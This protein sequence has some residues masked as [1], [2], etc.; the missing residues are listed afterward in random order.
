MWE[1]SIAAAAAQANKQ[2][3]V[4]SSRHL[5]FKMLKCKNAL[6][7][8]PDLT[9]RKCGNSECFSQLVP[10]DDADWD[11]PLVYQQVNLGQDVSRQ[12][13]HSLQTKKSWISIYSRK[14]FWN[15]GV[16]FSL[17]RELANNRTLSFKKI[18]K[19]TPAYSNTVWSGSALGAARRTL[20]NSGLAV[21]NAR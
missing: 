12:Q 3:F 4:C 7:Y 9:S 5:H 10:F 20:S 6:N 16:E 13:P 15:A 2:K 14:V 11:V 18:E 1:H 21:Y 8:L 19:L 17:G